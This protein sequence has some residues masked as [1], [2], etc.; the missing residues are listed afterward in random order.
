MKI[1]AVAFDAAYP[2]AAAA[3]QGETGATVLQIDCRAVLDRWPGARLSIVAKRPDGEAYP[4]LAAA[5]PDGKG[6]VP[7]ALTTVDTAVPGT[8][9]LELQAR[10][11]AVLVRSI[12]YA[13]E[14]TRQL[15]PPGTAAPPDAAPWV[16]VAL[17]AVHDSTVAAEQARA[18]QA[19]AEAA[20]RAAQAAVSDFTQEEAQRQL[21][22]AARQLAENARTIAEGERQDAELEREGRLQ[23]ALAGA[24]AAM[25]DAVDLAGEAAQS[26]RLAGDGALADGQAAVEMVQ[27]AL[28]EIALEA[29]SPLLFARHGAAMELPCAAHTR[30]TVR[31]EGNA[32]VTVDGRAYDTAD[33]RP[34]CV[35]VERGPVRIEAAE[36][37]YA[38]YNRDAMD[39]LWALAAPVRDEGLMCRLDDLLDDAP[40]DIEVDAVCAR[41]GEGLP[42]PQ[43][44]RPIVPCADLRLTRCGENLL[45]DGPLAQW[46]D[47]QG[48]A[49]VSHTRVSIS[50]R[51]PLA[52][53]AGRAY[54][55]RCEVASPEGMNYRPVVYYADGTN[56]QPYQ[57]S[58]GTYK[59]YVFQTNAVKAPVAF[60][61]D[62]ALSSDAV[63]VRGLM[64][65]TDAA[66]VWA[67]YRGTAFA[68]ETED[69]KLYGLPGYA[70]SLWLRTGGV[71]RRTGLLSL[72]DL[73]GW[74]SAGD[75]S[76]RAPLSG[77]LPGGAVWCSHFAAALE[78]GSLLVSGTGL[79]DLAAF[80]TYLR[81]ARP[82]AVYALAEPV[83]ESIGRTWD[84]PALGG[85]NH[86]LTPEGAR[87]TGLSGGKGIARRLAVLEGKV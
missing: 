76:W 85:T 11:G 74:E 36:P 21:E 79:T 15:V 9:E 12:A 53:P 30:V 17:D 10:D 78:A 27:T 55:V 52:L 2:Q 54:T 57:A 49:W 34:L 47:R 16:D 87:V 69:K 39:L 22:E 86:I 84:I 40:L 67:A 56:T 63:R 50:Y 37:L 73:P 51:I 35:A 1:Y 3:V 68:V 81:E 77:H 58:D 75:G 26:A 66:A 61:F 72:A 24:E 6:I 7:Y 41:A 80:T 8:L 38:T 64:V 60:G 82:E 46:F 14:V 28:D 45:D 18:A 31:P 33:G 43:N 44:V 19:D 62:C 29:A 42:S 83:R 23:R 71:T 20:G 48:D 4:A 25:E 65:T 5:L 13:V 32:R 59:A 70:D